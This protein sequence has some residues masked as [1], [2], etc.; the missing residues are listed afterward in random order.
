MITFEP[1][2]PP[3]GTKILE[4][5]KLVGWVLSTINQK[6]IFTVGDYIHQTPL[7]SFEQ[8]K[9]IACDYILNQ[10]QENE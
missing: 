7:D 2:N 5:G 6:W 3:C 1:T 10:R 4:Y 8:A 9:L